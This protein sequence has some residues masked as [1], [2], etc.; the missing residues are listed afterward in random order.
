M[1]KRSCP[2][3]DSILS[4]SNRLAT[5][6]RSP[7]RIG[8]RTLTASLQGKKVPYNLTIGDWDGRCFTPPSSMVTAIGRYYQAEQTV[9]YGP[10]AGVPVLRQAVAK[11]WQQTTGLP[12]Q[13]EQV[14]ITGGAR[15]LLY[16]AC[17]AILNPTD[18]VLYSA[19]NWNIACYLDLVLRPNTGSKN[20]NHH[21]IRLPSNPEQLFLLDVT[22]LDAYRDQLQ[23][24]WLNLPQNPSGCCYS[25]LQWYALL[26]LVL[27]LNY[28]R[29]QKQRRPLFV[30]IDAVY[31]R[32]NPAMTKL[33]QLLGDFPE[34]ASV[35]LIIDGMSKG[36]AATGMRVGWAVGPTDWIT[37]MAQDNLQL[38]SWPGKP[39]QLAAADFLASPDQVTAFTTRL[40]QKLQQSAEPLQTVVQQLITAGYPLSILPYQGGLYLAIHLPLKGFRTPE[41]SRLASA[42]DLSNYLINQF[43]LALV[44]F[45]YLDAPEHAWWFRLALGQGDADFYRAAAQVLHAAISALTP[46]TK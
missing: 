6:R 43:G 28:E 5:I 8:V 25:L 40:Q 3:V 4:D 45:Q 38:G 24:L 34:L 21:R 10:I 33:W 22:Q 23:L 18:M 16:L 15:A 42:E 19:P 13:P 27:Q 35:L 17:R 30:L 2:P 9:N 46:P 41:G 32:L 14:L 26:Q 7:A 44:S 1:P 37:A 20:D 11:E 12:Y 36:F 39:E 31:H 29:Q